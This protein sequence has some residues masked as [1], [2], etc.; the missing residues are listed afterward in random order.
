[1]KRTWE[2]V[3]GII[4]VSIAVIFLIMT[5]IAAVYF[6]SIDL[7]EMVDYSLMTDSEFSSSEVD[8][9][10]KLFMGMLWVGIISLFIALAGGLIAIFLLKGGK[11]KGAGIL[12]II[13]GILTIFH[14]WPLIFFIIPG[15]MCLVRKPGETVEVIE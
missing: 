13:T 1:M 10:I 14:V 7:K 3:L 6:N 12:L 2:Y 5:I 11:A 9:S 4:G 15:I 8:M